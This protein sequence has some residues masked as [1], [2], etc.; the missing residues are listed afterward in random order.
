ML[1]D[2]LEPDHPCRCSTLVNHLF[3]FA[4]IS[5]SIRDRSHK[6]SQYTSTR[7][8]DLAQM[9][10]KGGVLR[11]PEG[12]DGP[13]RCGA[14]PSMSKHYSFSDTPSS[15]LISGRI[16]PRGVSRRQDAPCTDYST[17]STATKTHIGVND[18]RVGL[19]EM[20]LCA[21]RPCHWSMNP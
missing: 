2:L 7:R 11:E 4:L 6:V 5:P 17:N 8:S 21:T 12:V 14:H 13:R 10:K 16:Q 15:A 19:T 9:A 3:A 18:V 1:R 20:S